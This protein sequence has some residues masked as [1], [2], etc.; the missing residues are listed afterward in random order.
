MTSMQSFLRTSVLTAA[1]RLVD[2]AYPIISIPILLTTF[3]VNDYAMLIATI[4][5]ISPL[6][7]VLNLAIDD[8]F[9]RIQLDEG[10]EAALHYLRILICVRYI[11]LA[12]FVLIPFVFGQTLFTLAI[13]SLISEVYSSHTYFIAS[14]QVR[15]Y[16]LSKIV[17]KLL[18][19]LMISFVLPV[20]VNLET[21]F[22]LLILSN[23]V[24]SGLLLA[25]IGARKDIPHVTFHGLVE[26]FPVI[27]NSF[28]LVGNNFVA[29]IRDKYPIAI[30]SAVSPSLAVSLDI[31]HKGILAINSVSS[32]FVLTAFA[33]V[34][35]I[36]ELNQ[37]RSILMCFTVASLVGTAMFLLYSDASYKLADYEIKAGYASLAILASTF[38]LYSIIVVKTYMIPRNLNI[39]ILIIS[40]LLALISN[41]L[42]IIYITSSALLFMPL[43]VF[44][45]EFVLRT[46]VSVWDNSRR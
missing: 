26:Y 10:L 41:G 8:V 24:F 32:A 28:Y 14:Q 23:L 21:Y 34:K 19:L 3:G 35:S 36:S 46:A 2:M 43:F 16:L 22:Y 6:Q 9:Q 11:F 25:K 12:I 15:Y 5:T 31:I 38:N 17:H 4:A 40:V 29:N 42:T 13:L 20:N 45:F 7:P 1:A 27:V 33:K 39:W 37:Y 44:G 30:L 18:L